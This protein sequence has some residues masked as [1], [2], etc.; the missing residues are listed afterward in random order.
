MLRIAREHVSSYRDI[1]NVPDSKGPVIMTGHQPALYHPGVWFKNFLVDRIASRV[2]GVAINVI[3][4]NDVAPA[5]SISALSGT[6]SEPRPTRIAYDQ[7]GPRV[8]WEMTH[9]ESMETLRSF[10]K[11][12][13]ETI[14]PFVTHPLVT[15]FW[16][17][18]VQEVEA[19]QPLGMA[20]SVARNCLEESCGLQILDV[21]LSKLCQTEWFCRIMGFV[22]TNA[23]HYREIYNQSVQVYRNVHKIRSASHPVPDLEMDD[24]W[25]EVPFWV[26][27]KENASRRRLWVSGSR[28]QVVLSDR[29][30]WQID[31]SCDQELP[32]HLQ[33]LT[34]QGICV[35]PRALMTTTILRLVASELFIHGIG[36]AKYDQ[37]TDEINHRLLSL[38][39]PAY[40]TATATA[41]LPIDVQPVSHDDLQAIDA[42]L[43]DAEFNP[44][45]AI[46][47]ALEK[48]PS[49][50]LLL[51]QKSSLLTN[52]PKISEKAEWHRQLQEVNSKLRSQIAEPVARLRIEREQIAGQLH[53][54]QLLTSR[55]Y[56]LLLF[57]KEGLRNLLLDLAEKEI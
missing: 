47:D 44:D 38:D 4:D 49:W 27:T 53:Q 5:P 57:S 45:R 11:R 41:Q 2:Q 12:T 30:G 55:E 50:Q 14:E 37:V 3:I 52:V 51:E 33:E 23:K 54:K 34:S 10:A 28:S 16:P 35:R 48:D 18:V 46:D 15:Q 6:P 19:G 7:P 36:G 13:A 32:L 1:S 17:Q 56:S 43:R 25:V 26:W 24:N 29:A 22:F 39:P 21:P 20:F 40:V 8:A 42:R 31:L 9:V